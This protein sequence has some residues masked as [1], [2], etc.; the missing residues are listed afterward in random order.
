[1][2][3][4]Q[5]FQLVEYRVVVD[6]TRVFGFINRDTSIERV[7]ASPPTIRDE[8]A[9]NAAR[10]DQRIWRDSAHPSPCT[11]ESGCARLCS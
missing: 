1:M 9:P 8:L 4:Y 11:L 2:L 5:S 6:L 10:T 3:S 7:Q